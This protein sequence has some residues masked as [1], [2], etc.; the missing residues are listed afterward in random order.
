MWHYGSD[1]FPFDFLDDRE[2]DLRSPIKWLPSIRNT[3]FVIEGTGRS[4]LFALQAMKRACTNPNVHFYPVK[5]ATHIT[6]LGPVAK[7][8]AEKV[9]RDTGP[10]T[11]I[12]MSEEELNKP[13]V[14]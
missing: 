14:D 5:H 4:N 3:T 6:V 11:N 12:T 2:M 1:I 10:E 8:I 9:R 13:F 7:I